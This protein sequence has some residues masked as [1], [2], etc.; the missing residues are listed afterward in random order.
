LDDALRRPAARPAAGRQ[1][2]G[3]VPLAIADGYDDAESAPVGGLASSL[4]LTGIA[5]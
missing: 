1:E 4:V 5:A 3:P 2:S